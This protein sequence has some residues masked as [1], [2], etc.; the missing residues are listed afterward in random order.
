MITKSNYLLLL[1]SF[2]IGLILTIFFLGY[3]NIGLTN[4]DWVTNPD[5]LSEFLALK[6]FLQD[7]WNFP[8]GLNSNY[9]EL[10]NSIVF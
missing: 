10:K 2:V 8:I 6:F 1:V 7:E 5:I 9:G 4:T 3:N